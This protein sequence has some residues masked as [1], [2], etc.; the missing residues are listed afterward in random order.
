MV[1]VVDANNNNRKEIQRAKDLILKTG[2]NILGVV[3]N[4]VKGK[5]DEYYAYYGEENS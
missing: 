2:A 4:K 5:S 3:L 1:L